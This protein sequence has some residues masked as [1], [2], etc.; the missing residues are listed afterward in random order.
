MCGYPDLFES[1]ELLWV[2]G[3]PRVCVEEAAPPLALEDAP[4]GEAQADWGGGELGED[5]ARKS[6]FNA[7]EV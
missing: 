4:R 5:L 7:Q 6:R 3:Q 1:P 2:E